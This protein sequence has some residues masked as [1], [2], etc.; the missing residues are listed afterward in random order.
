[1]T[2]EAAG[3]VEELIVR[4]LQQRE[5]ARDSGARIRPLSRGRHGFRQVLRRSAQ[6]ANHLRIAELVRP[7]ERGFPM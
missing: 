2:G 3:F 6:F 1:M 7:V 5:T 4:A